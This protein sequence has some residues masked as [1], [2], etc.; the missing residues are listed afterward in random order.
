MRQEYDQGGFETLDLA[1]GALTRY[2][3]RKVRNPELK[4]QYEGL[5]VAQIA[6][7]ENK[8]VVDAMLDVSVADDLRTEWAGP[9]TNTNIEGFRD[10]MDSPY[11]LPGLS[12]GGAHVKFITPAIYPTEV[13][14]WLVRDAGII[15]LEEAHFRLSEFMIS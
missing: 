1:F 8:H 6:E 15:S 9:T 11:T 10:I 12:D 13:L 14:S 5:S 3:A 4:A 7:K 2:I